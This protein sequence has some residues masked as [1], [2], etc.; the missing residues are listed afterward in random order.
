L[1]PS[2]APSQAH[3]PCWPTPG[4]D[5]HN[6]TDGGQ[7]SHL[8]VIQQH[9]SHAVYEGSWHGLVWMPGANLWKWNST[10]AASVFD[11][12]SVVVIGSSPHRE[13]ASHF[14]LQVAGLFDKEPLSKDPNSMYADVCR[15]LGSSMFA[16]RYNST[17]V[18]CEHHS[19]DESS[20]FGCADCFCCCECQFS[21]GCSTHDFSLH[22]KKRAG[23]GT[24]A[25]VHFTNQPELIH[26]R[27]E[28]RAMASRFCREPPDLLVV[29]KGVHDSYFDEY[30]VPDWQ[31]PLIYNHSLNHMDADRIS[32]TEFMA[33]QRPLLH[34]YIK[35]MFRCLPQTTL[36]VMLAPYH[37]HKASWQPKLVNAHYEILLSLLANGDLLRIA[38]FFLMRCS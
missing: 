16:A 22:L 19:C 33:R 30:T 25:V 27:S 36:I 37:S 1:R 29:S 18:K 35:T 15:P 14:P 4:T 8:A 20:G 3:T 13:L 7:P 31:L 2:K 17:G 23:A 28:A 9:I 12:R 26:T 6:S 34:N 10:S 38:S 11:G 32:P 24:N 5:S 21:H